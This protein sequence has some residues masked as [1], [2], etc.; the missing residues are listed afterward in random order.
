MNLNLA[1]RPTV[2]RLVMACTLIATFNMAAVRLQAQEQAPPTTGSAL[3]TAVDPNGEAIK[4][5]KV[6]LTSNAMANP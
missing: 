2:A 3:G 5:A 1:L 6:A 4:G